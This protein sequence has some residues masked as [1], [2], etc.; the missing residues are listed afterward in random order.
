MSTPSVDHDSAAAIYG[1][2]ADGSLVGLAGA[3]V[4]PV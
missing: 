2:G 1:G 4:C 3:R